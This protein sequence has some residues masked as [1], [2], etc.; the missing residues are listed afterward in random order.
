MFERR[1]LSTQKS[2]LAPLRRLESHSFGMPGASRK[3]MEKT[4]GLSTIFLLLGATVMVLM[5][6][7]LYQAGN[8]TSPAIDGTAHNSGNSVSTLSVSLRTTNPDVVIVLVGINTAGGSA[9]VQG[10]S[11][12]DL[13]FHQRATGAANSM[14][15]E[16][17]YSVG[18]AALSSE[19]IT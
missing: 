19:T 15:F 3:A 8:A 7:V 4:L 6:S 18:G 13:S 11:S 10:V 5:P 2:S 9:T 17:W 16:E 12:P 1:C 14:Y